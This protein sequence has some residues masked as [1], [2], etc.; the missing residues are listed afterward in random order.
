MLSGLTGVGRRTRIYIFVCSYTC[1]LLQVLC[2]AFVVTLLPLFACLEVVRD[3]TS[4]G[5]GLIRTMFCAHKKL[6]FYKVSILVEVASVLE[7]EMK[8][9]QNILF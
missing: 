1:F 3:G 2:S 6:L 8:F 4:I 5:I 9:S 7:A